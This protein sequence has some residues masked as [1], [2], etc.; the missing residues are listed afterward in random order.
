MIYL[1]IRGR[2]GNQMFQYAF[3]RKLSI[4]NHNERIVIDFY[5]IE[6][7][8]VKNPPNQDE[9]S[10][11]NACEHY[12]KIVSGKNKIEQY[13]SNWQFFIFRLFRNI[14]EKLCKNGRINRKAY[15]KSISRVLSHWG[16]ILLL[17]S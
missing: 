17:R 1:D 16:N 7:D 10:M 2:C 13:G 9:L 5:N 8:I 12:N 11:L 6:N 15:R 4:I 3:A 14:E